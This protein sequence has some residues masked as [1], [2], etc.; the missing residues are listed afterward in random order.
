MQLYLIII[1]I[2]FINKSFLFC[3]VEGIP[4]QPTLNENNRNTS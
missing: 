3:M 2:L 1:G 4:M